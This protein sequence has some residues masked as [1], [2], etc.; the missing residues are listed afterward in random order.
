V[1]ERRAK[2]SFEK[3]PEAARFKDFRKMIDDH[4]KD[5]D[6][7][8]VAT[9][10][11]THAAATIASIWA[12]KHVYCEKPLAHSIFEVREMQ[13]AAAAK[14]V[15]TQMGNQGH[16]FESI[17][18]FCEWIWDGAIGEVHTIHAG[19]NANHSKIGQLAKMSEKHPV[20]AELD[21]DLWLGPQHLRPY[22][23]M[24]LPGNWRGWS[25]FGTG[26]IGD[27]TCHVLDPVFWALDLASPATVKAEAKDYDPRKHGETF[28]NG[29]VITYTF[30]KR[31]TRGPL[32][33]IW[34][35]G[36]E[37]LP[38]PPE[39]EPDRKLPEAGAIV[40]GTKG[41]IMYGSHGA[42]GVRIFPEKKMNEYKQPIKRLPR[43]K[44]HHQDWINA[45]RTGKKAGSDFVYGGQLTEMALVGVI[46]TKLLG[47]ELKWNGG[48]FIRNEDA[49]ALMKPTFR[50]GWGL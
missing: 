5:F 47:Q 14:Q 50:R 45:I 28:P 42:S 17:R 13:R 33:L 48:P 43:V 34:H 1:D 8:V 37:S 46:A 27:W 24:Y 30:A 35:D 25:A 16:S 44:G 32:K 40:L 10:D 2:E 21:W 49:N 18:V 36:T 38:R 19:C 12:S 29:T 20:P 39:M 22:N 26:T 4:Q 15:V 31:G 9:P 7:V 3:F 11:H 41:G 6:A 23:P